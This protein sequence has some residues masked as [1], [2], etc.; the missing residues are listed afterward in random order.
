MTRF[1]LQRHDKKKIVSKKRHACK[2]CLYW[3]QRCYRQLHS[4]F[5]IGMTKNE[6]LSAILVFLLVQYG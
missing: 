6:L 3:G 2:A 5:E 4:N 1:G